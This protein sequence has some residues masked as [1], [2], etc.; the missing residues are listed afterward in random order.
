MRSVLAAGRFHLEIVAPRNRAEQTR[1]QRV[2]LYHRQ[3]DR[4][5]AIASIR[6]WP[7]GVTVMNQSER[8][9]DRNTARAEALFKK[10]ER[11]KDGERAMAQYEAER[12]AMQEK[13]ARL[14]A[15]RLARDAAAAT[16]R[17]PKPG[18]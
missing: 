7:P 9:H 13:T 11:L 16:T 12:R 4:R 5:R 10:Q 15:L 8:V 2:D 17:T 6:Y 14:R 18:F 1:T 3:I